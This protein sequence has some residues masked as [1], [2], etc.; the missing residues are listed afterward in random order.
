MSTITTITPPT[1][2]DG[3]N[4]GEINGVTD[5]AMLTISVVTM[6]LPLLTIKSLSQSSLIGRAA[7]GDRCYRLAV[8]CVLLLCFLLLIATTALWIKLSLLNAEKDQ[9]QATYST[10]IITRDQLQTQYSNLIAERN[11][12]RT[13]NIQVMFERNYLQDRNRNLT[14]ESEQQ[15]DR[16]EKLQSRLNTLGKYLP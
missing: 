13:S 15:Q 10:L 11:Q 5:G 3:N 6:P 12:L 7:A 1:T 9:L 2:T 14:M 16:I 8:A 4:G